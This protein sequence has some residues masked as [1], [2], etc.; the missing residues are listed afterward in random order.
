[1]IETLII[2]GSFALLS[3]G[4]AFAVTRSHYQRRLLELEAKLREAQEKLRLSE[5]A[6]AAAHAELARLRE[7]LAERDRRLSD[8][9]ESIAALRD[10]TVDLDRRLESHG[11][12]TRRA[13]AAVTLRLGE[14]RREED[15]MRHRLH[16]A[17]QTI[18]TFGQEE[19]DL[20]AAVLE[21]QREERTRVKAVETAEAAATE[22]RAE[23][24]RRAAALKEA[25]GA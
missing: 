24:E 9:A 18:E 10:L 17:K 1:M 23:A 14:H 13:L 22:T 7:Q 11:K 15:D 19:T 20:Q 2:G 21:I 25:M 3:G 5:E 12:F 8:L 6:L 16:H 4:G